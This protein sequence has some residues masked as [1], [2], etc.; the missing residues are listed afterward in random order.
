[1]SKKKKAQIKKTVEE[2]IGCIVFGLAW[3]MFFAIGF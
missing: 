1:M 2:I 3:A